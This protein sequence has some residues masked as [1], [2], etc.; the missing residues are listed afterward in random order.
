MNR[1][2]EI[3]TENRAP[4]V[5]P[6]L[7]TLAVAAAHG[8]T[9]T[10]RHA[11]NRM[12]EIARTASNL[13]QFIQ[14]VDS[15]RGWGRALKNGINNWYVNKPVKDMVY[16]VL[17]YR[18][19]NGWTHRDVLRKTHPVVTEERSNVFAYITSEG[20][21]WDP[22]MEGTELINTFIEAQNPETSHADLLKLIT[23]YNLTWEFLPTE[24]L[25]K[26]STWETML[27][28]LPMTALIRNL[29][30]LTKLEVLRPLTDN[31]SLVVQKLTDEQNVKRSRI[32]PL[33]AL[34]ALSTYQLGHGQRG[35]LS[36]RPV[37]AIIDALEETFELA[38]TNVEPTGKNFYFAVD[39]SGSMTQLMMNTAITCQQAAAALAMVAARKEKNHHLA[40]FSSSDGIRGYTRSSGKMQQ[41][42]ITSKSSLQNVIKVLDPHLAWGR[43]DCAL[44]MIDALEKK[45]DVDCFVV[46][47]DNE[48]WHGQIHPTQALN[49][50]RKH[51]KRDAKL[52]V[53]G[54]TATKFSIADP[55]D[56][57]MM[58]IV[59]FDSA[60]PALIND[61]IT[62]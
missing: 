55:N 49:N 61:F 42:P 51:T 30:R 50:Y 37:P 2:A 9:L 46:L 44:P 28:T 38:F 20:K 62:H 3:S 58:D 6:V 36:W 39:V 40:F 59:G 25:A 56:A 18:N 54:M 4:R 8:D 33:G 13:L 41:L 35:G 29:G 17:K 21:K 52:V 5:G 53:A 45:M 60:M 48:T 27:P 43:T 11:M 23:S 47:T 14:Y 32:H 10:R 31:T 16:Q 34:I 22:D 19:R 15:M 1:V 12:P 57:G 24:A 26:T 7:F